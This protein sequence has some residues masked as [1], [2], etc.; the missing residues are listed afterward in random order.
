M[1]KKIAA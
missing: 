1:F